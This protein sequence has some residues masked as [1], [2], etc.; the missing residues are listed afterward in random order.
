MIV[1]PG[2]QTQP[3]AVMVE[4]AVVQ[5]QLQATLFIGGNMQRGV[6]GITAA[7]MRQPSG[8]SLT[9]APVR[10]IF[11]LSLSLMLKLPRNMSM[12]AT[13]APTH[14]QGVSVLWRKIRR[15]WYVKAN[16]SGNDVSSM[17]V[18]RCCS[19]FIVVSVKIG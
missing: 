2:G 14:R 5:I 12:S 17:A 19:E 7:E 15:W 11:S 6:D 10:A 8:D 1:R 18:D 13:P 4:I 16:P 3:D 9:V